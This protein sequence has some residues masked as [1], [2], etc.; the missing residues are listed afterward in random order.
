MVTEFILTDGDV[1]NVRP[2]IALSTFF[3][4]A[5]LLE[6]NSAF[7]PSL[8]C[9]RIIN[10]DTYFACLHLLLTP[11]LKTLEATNVPDHQHPTFFSFLTTLVHKTPLLEDITLGPGRFPL[12]SL[13][14][15]FK[16]THLRRLELKDVA[17]TIDFVFF[18]DLGVLP[19][20]ES[21][22]LD[23]RSCEYT[24]RILE[25]PSGTLPSEDTEVGSQ[26]PKTS[27]DIDDDGPSEG[28]F[29]SPILEDKEEVDHHPLQPIYKQTPVD[30]RSS[31]TS[32]VGGF[33]HLKKFHLVGGLPLIQDI[34]PYIA[35]STL[36]DISITNIRLSFQDLKDPITPIQRMEE[37][38][39]ADTEAENTRRE[40]KRNEEEETRK[41]IEAMK[42]RMRRTRQYNMEQS[43]RSK[44]RE[45]LEEPENRWKQ[46]EKIERDRRAATAAE[47]MQER[48]QASFDL[49]TASYI[50]VLRTASSRWSADLKAVRF[51]QLDRS[52]QPL[53]I[54][55]ALS[56]QVYG[57]LFCHPKIEI[58]EFKRWKLDS[59]EDFLF[60]LKTS[61]PKHLKQLYLPLDG[62]DN[63]AVSLYDL[64]DIA[65]ACP[66]LDILQCCMSTLPQQIPE[67]SVPA[68]QKVLSH[69]LQHLFVANHPTLPWDFNE[70]LLVARHLYLLFPH[71]QTIYSVE[72]PKAEQWVR[73]RD[74]IKMFQTIRKDDVYRFSLKS[75]F[76]L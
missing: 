24:P 7:L 36:E 52:S 58:L 4:I 25:D 28:R 68:G 44:R 74:L 40:R 48:I 76:Q 70:L 26:H 59:V 66:M 45:I 29:S 53:S 73:I 1:E 47:R 15:I 55:P 33:Y 17:L 9:L 21:F 14:A 42:T 67:Y 65:E 5:R 49:H 54:T 35:S 2:N 64:L 62:P 32:M 16:F 8:L 10:A 37:E 31:S 60:S 51:N 23:A 56:E 11:S 3:H 41:S 75:V 63:S 6:P 22:I 20:L 19:N 61:S 30:T 12:R 72:G 13:Q 38:A 69:G 57:P 43:I 27:S 46:E 50:S 71:L 18:Q 34:V 39:N